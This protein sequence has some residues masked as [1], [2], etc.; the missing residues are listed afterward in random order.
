MKV[1]IT[2]A[3]GF[4]GSQLLEALAIQHPEWTLVASDIRPLNPRTLRPNVEAVQL[5][6]GKRAAVLAAVAQHR[7]DAIVH[8]ASVVTP[9]PG[10]SEAVLHAIDVEGTRSILQAAV[11][12]GVGQLVVT[13]SGAFDIF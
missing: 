3:A 4:I 2:G 8:L 6:I 12:Q 1:F 7:P 9:P 11:E 5:D 13:S 10:M